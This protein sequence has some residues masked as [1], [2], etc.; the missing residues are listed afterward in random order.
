MN[1]PSVIKQETERR[2]ESY[3]I[4]AFGKNTCSVLDL[5]ARYRLLTFRRNNPIDELLAVTFFDV[6]MF[7]GSG[8]NYIETNC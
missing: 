8:H 6:R 4:R 1:A 7:G 3:R 5:V 2:D